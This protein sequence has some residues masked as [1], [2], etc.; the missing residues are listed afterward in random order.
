MR[1]VHQDPPATP[2]AEETKG[3]S[4]SQ[5]LLKRL[6]APQDY[7]RRWRMIHALPGAK[8]GEGQTIRS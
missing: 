5:R 3:Q 4:D 2:H 1:R 6:V 8:P 7:R